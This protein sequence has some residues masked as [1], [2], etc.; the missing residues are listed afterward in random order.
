MM[1]RH[2]V[3]NDMPYKRFIFLWRHFHLKEE[4]EDEE[5]ANIGEDESKKN[6]DEL[7]ENIY[8]ATTKIG[9][10]EG[11]N[12]EERGKTIQRGKRWTTMVRVRH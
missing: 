12:S 8:C 1:P 7:L 11:D 9:Q 5:V 10:E 6:E 3:K 2:A 4:V